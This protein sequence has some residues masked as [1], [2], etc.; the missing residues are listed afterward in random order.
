VVLQKEVKDYVHRVRGLKSAYGAILGV[1]QKAHE[2]AGTM[3]QEFLDGIQHG[4]DHAGAGIPLSLNDMPAWMRIRRELSGA[5][6]TKEIIPGSLLI[7]AVSQFDFLYGK[8]VRK[9]FTIRPDLMLSE[10]GE[11]KLAEVFRY[12]RVEDIR[13]AVIE[14]RVEGLLRKSHDDQIGWLESA[15][16]VTLRADKELLGQFIEITER[17]NLLVHCEG[18]VGGQY[19]S[20]CGRFDA[21]HEGAQRGSKLSVDEA[22]FSRSCDLLLEIGVKVSQIMWRKINPE[23]ANDANLFYN[24]VCFD[25]ISGGDLAVAKRLL[26]FHKLQWSRDCRDEHRL[27]AALNLAQCYKWMGEGDQCIRILQEFEWPTRAPLFQLGYHVLMGEFDVAARLMAAVGEDVLPRSCYREWPIF[28]EFIRSEQFSSA[29]R[30][31][32]SEEFE[33]LRAQA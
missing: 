31:L 32:F 4:N 9:L 10:Q 24:E 23:G 16:S 33:M 28:Q 2:K 27:R 14:K 8:M 15:L 20:V 13:E 21:V 22:Y 19:L 29:Y 18:V 5:S 3:M 25:L 17:R 11:I 1:A 6:Q 26:L 30:D 12:E 7:A